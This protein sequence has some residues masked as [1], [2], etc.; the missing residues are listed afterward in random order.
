MPQRTQPSCDVRDLDGKA[1]AALEEARELPPG[2]ERTEAMKSWHFSE[3][4]LTFRAFSLP[5]VEGPQSE[6][7]DGASVPAL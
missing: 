1:T 7:A 2:P 4:P 3:T 6:T 5:S